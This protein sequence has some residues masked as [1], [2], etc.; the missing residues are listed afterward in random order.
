[1]SLT[2]RDVT[3]AF[4]GRTVL[5]G[6]SLTVD[7]GQTVGLRG[8]SGVGKTTLARALA[9]LVPVQ[10]GQVS[11]DGRAPA[12]RGRMDGNIAMLFQSPRR[13][14]SPRMRLRQVIAETLPRRADV[15]DQLHRLAAEVG[16]TDDLLDRLPD[17]VSDGQLQRAALARALAARPRYLIC[18]EA[19]AMLDSVTTAQ[20]V[21]VLRRRAADGLGVLAISHDEKLLSAWAD[22]VV[23]LN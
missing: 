10:D 15:D 2:A 8:P 12:P 23:E 21:Q 13:S 17:E 5:H 1:M 14:C 22:R 18:D 11:C 20:V 16:L 3:V 19:T 6:V 7:P 9:G 4:D